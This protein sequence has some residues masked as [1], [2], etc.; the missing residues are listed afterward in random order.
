MR[1]FV[2]AF[3]LAAVVPAGAHHPFTPYY[4]ASKLTV[5]TGV[6][7]ELR[8]ANPHAVLI[9]DGTTSDGRSGRWA[10]EGLAPGAYK[11]RNVKDVREMLRAGTRITISGWAARDPAAPAF[12]ASEVTFDDGSKMVFGSLTPGASD[13]WHCAREPCPAYRYPW[14]PSN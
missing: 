9:V 8:Y 5:V 13:G 11:Y 10:F 12:S 14:V 3:V 6:V 7:V 1:L 4:D 2:A